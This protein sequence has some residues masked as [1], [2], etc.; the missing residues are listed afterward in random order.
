M[1]HSC[2]SIKNDLWFDETVISATEVPGFQAFGWRREEISWKAPG[3]QKQKGLLVV[4]EVFN[5]LLG[6]PRKLVNG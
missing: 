1:K 5:E 2:F 6:C 4:E 3:C